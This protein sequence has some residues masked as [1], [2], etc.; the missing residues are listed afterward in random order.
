[1]N[2]DWGNVM[3]ITLTALAGV[4]CALVLPWLKERLGA[5]K[6]K[7]LWKWV[8]VAVQAA[9]QIFGPGNGAR[10]KEYALDILNAQGIKAEGETLD[11]LIEAA[12][13]DLT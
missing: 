7:A 12:V 9:E 1:M 10:K 3:H 6:L 2:I 4:V 5:E 13:R 11:V 8:C